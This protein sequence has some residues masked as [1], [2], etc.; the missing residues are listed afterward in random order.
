P[1]GKLVA[2]GGWDSPQV[3]ALAYHVYIFDRLTG[4]ILQRLGPNPQVTNELAFSLDGKR[5]AAGFGGS[6]TG[7]K[8]WNTADWSEVFTDSDYGEAVHGA[9]FD[10]K[11]NLATVSFD[12]MIR[13]YDRSL[14]L[15]ARVP[16]P[17]GER[18]YHA[19]FSP[20]GKLLA[21]GYVGTPTV[22]I[23]D[24]PRLKLAYRADTRGI[25]DGDVAA[26]TWSD[27]GKLLYASGDYYT[28]APKERMILFQW[29]NKGRGKR[30]SF[31][32]AGNT[33]MDLKPL[34]GGG[35]VLSAADHSFTVYDRKGNILFRKL[36]I[37]ADMSGKIG[38]SFM[39]S[40][41]GARVRFGL[42]SEARDPWMFDV[43]K[44]RFTASD[45]APADLKTPIV[46]S[47]PIENWNSQAD[48]TLAGS[49]IPLDRNEI[50]R[51][52]AIESDAESFVLGTDWA[53]RRFTGKGTVLWARAV[54]EVSWGVNITGKDS[55]LVAAHADGTIRWYRLA[56]GAELL[57]LFVNAQDKRWIAWTPKGYYAASPGGE[58]LMGWQVNRSWTEAPDFFPAAQFHERFYRPDIVKQ[59]I[60]SLDEDRAIAEANAAAKRGESKET[61]ADALPPVVEIVDPAP[62]T[63][64]SSN[65]VTIRYRVRT[66][67]GEK[68]TGIEVLIDGRPPGTRGVE[69]IDEDSDI[70][71]LDVTIPSRDVEVAII[72]SLGDSVSAPARLKLKWAGAPSEDQIKR[73]L[74]AVF[75]GVSDYDDP[76][77]KLGFADADAQ[78]FEAEARSQ[79][80]KLYEAVETRLLLNKDATA[81]NIRG[82]LSWLEEK[83]GPED[84]GLLFLAGHGVT[85]AKQRF[86]FLP[87]GGNPDPDKLRATA[88]SESEIRESIASIAGRMLFF[89]DACHSAKS[90][91]ADQSD[92]DVTAVINRM[93]RADS[94]VVMFA[95]SQGR[96]L[97][98]ESPEW[99][100]GA[101]TAVLLSGVAGGAD[102]EKDG[103]ITTAELNLWLSTKVKELTQNRQTAVMLKPDT[104]PDFPVARASE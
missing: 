67:S 5:L 103:A 52:L 68:P 76:D 23:L 74:Y 79:Q 42:G 85:D 6:N 86:Y 49:P 98:L 64:V 18:P 92:A 104:V 58:D 25:E 57:A 65:I 94:G 15:I 14:K 32:A 83:V 88:V 21:V 11:G 19:S 48:P 70:Q 4:A 66:S 77:L 27:D 41:D 40:E 75:V 54:P 81:D 55:I 51:S 16:A 30:A 3:N 10:A 26:V 44:L 95:S 46:D 62:E 31:D 20:D 53:L 37:A 87:V 93:A 96:E 34:P 8:A 17:S 9:V 60:L 33:V 89:I 101:F 91:D 47:L 45:E 61:I 69:T 82:A 97:S 50:S 63:K 71:S 7:I 29:Q 35:A 84:V 73:K 36:P 59:V 78:G 12:G 100:H 43:A 80:G 38:P 28:K 56:D 1:D 39:V 24:V 2:A 99:K 22:D 102:Y 72:A 13:L 90:L